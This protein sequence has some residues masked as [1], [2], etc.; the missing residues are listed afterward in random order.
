MGNPFSGVPIAV[1]F[2]ARGGGCGA[3]QVLLGGRAPRSG[4]IS[5]GLRR[6]RRRK[7]GHVDALPER[8]LV[9]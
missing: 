6:Q 9:A 1:A 5:F 4:T 8:G 2:P 7:L 3:E